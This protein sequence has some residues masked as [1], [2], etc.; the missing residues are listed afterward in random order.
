MQV[1]FERP[2]FS[3]KLAR[4]LWSPLMFLSAREGTCTS[5]GGGSLGQRAGPGRWPVTGVSRGPALHR[6]DLRGFTHQS[7]SFRDMGELGWMVCGNPFS[8]K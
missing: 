1:I 3:G 4:L 2:A 6:C 8:M 7:L 5:V